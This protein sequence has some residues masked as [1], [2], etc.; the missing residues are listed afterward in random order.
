MN[1][2]K[3]MMLRMTV[4]ILIPVLLI[5]IGSYTM[6]SKSLKEEAQDK[7][8]SMTKMYSI[9]VENKLKSIQGIIQVASTN[10]SLDS[11]LSNNTL[12]TKTSVKQYLKRIQGN[13]EGLIEMMILLDKNGDALVSDTKTDLSINVNHRQYFKDTLAGKEGLMSDVL[14]NMET[15]AASVVVTEPIKVDGSI[16]GMLIATIKFDVIKDIVSEIKIGTEGYGYLINNE[17]LLIS[18]PDAKKENTYNL[19]EAGSEELNAILDNMTAGKYG[20]GYYEFEGV[21]KYVA[22]APVNGWS[23]ASTA[24]YDDYMAPALQI[25]KMSIIIALSAMLVSVVSAYAFT[26]FGLV[27]PIQKLVE[28]MV[29]AGNGD[30]TARTDIKTKDEVRLLGDTFNEMMDMQGNIIAEIRE[31]SV[32]LMDTAEEL[33]ASAQDTSATTEEIT[34][35]ID[36]IANDAFEQTEA[37][38]SANSHFTD[39]MSGVRQTQ[40]LA[41]ESY[42]DSESALAVAEEGRTLIKE[43]VSSINDISNS[44]DETV[45]VLNELDETAKEVS[46]ISSTI[47][48]IADSINLLALNAS[49][50]AARAGEHGRGFNVVAEEI[51][52]LAEQTSNESQEIQ[53]L[54][55]DI[56]KQVNNANSSIHATKTSVDYGVQSVSQVDGMF[57]EIIGSVENVVE[58]IT[59]IKSSAQ[60]ESEIADEMSTIVMGVAQMAQATSANT[61]EIS[62]GSEE[63]AAITETMSASA[64]ETSAMAESLNGMVQHFIV[65]ESKASY[66]HKTIKGNFK[67]HDELPQVVVTKSNVG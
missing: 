4:L 48:G 66:D 33:A 40:Q 16:E 27:K 55:N 25:R 19:Y 43:T 14:I 21:Y 9:M 60:K 34:A 23:I 63:Q 59:T 15:N 30:L 26:K 8:K 28:A 53:S 51:R 45:T 17:G 12:E 52:K 65:N 1:L 39:L 24:N 18:H 7:A 20:E 42:K 50:E 61:Q 5:G 38:E 2:M 54:L 44:T 49:I 29:K 47:N 46:G 36:E 6:A 58:R 13:N 35:K 37:V 22:Y 31:A 3:K 56:L 64:E 11:L 67:K 62:A 32:T 10:E 57:T 41:E